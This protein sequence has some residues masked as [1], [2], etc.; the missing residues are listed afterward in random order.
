MHIV[1]ILDFKTPK[2]HSPLWEIAK[3]SSNP[4]ASVLLPIVPRKLTPD[5]LSRSPTHSGPESNFKAKKI[6]FLILSDQDGNF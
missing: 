3:K 5:K 6:K 4:M 2:S 1:A